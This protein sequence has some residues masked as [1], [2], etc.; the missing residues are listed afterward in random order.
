MPVKTNKHTTQK[1]MVSLRRCGDTISPKEPKL[2]NH[3]PCVRS[4][5]TLS[6]PTAGRNYLKRQNESH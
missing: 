2:I 1:K 4:E 5:E 6:D 3:R